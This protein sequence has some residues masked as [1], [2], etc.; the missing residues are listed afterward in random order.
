MQKNETNSSQIN[1]KDL[2]TFVGFKDYL[3]LNFIRDNLRNEPENLYIF[4]SKNMYIGFTGERPKNE[5]ILD[6]AKNF[7]KNKYKPIKI[8]EFRTSNLWDIKFYYNKLRSL[9]KGKYIVNIS[10]GPGIYSAASMLWSIESSN[11]ISY[12]VEIRDGETVKS[13]IFKNLNLFP[14]S[15]LSFKSDNLDRYIVEAIKNGMNTTKEIKDYLWK[16]MDYKTSVRN[17][18]FHITELVEAGVLSISGSKPYNISFSSYM[19]NLGYNSKY[20]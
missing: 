7:L 20:R 14:F 9:P 13:S 4:T 1:N 12:S 17:I 5:V 2:I 11:E 16:E 3:V 15:Y 10:S 8:T 18:Q 6:Q 19:E